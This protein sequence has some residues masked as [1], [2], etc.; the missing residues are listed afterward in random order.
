MAKNK[1]HK[2]KRY[3]E[4]YIKQ[5]ESKIKRLEKQPLDKDEIDYP[6]YEEA[7]NLINSAKNMLKPCTHCKTGFVTKVNIID[8]QYWRCSSCLRTVK[9]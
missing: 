6:L 2:Q 4:G 1:T 8:R 5:L 9:V 7:D 3:L